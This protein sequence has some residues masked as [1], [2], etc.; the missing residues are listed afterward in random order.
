MSI[1]EGYNEATTA[2][3]ISVGF[4]ALVYIILFSFLGG[5]IRILKR[6][7]SVSENT[8]GRS[9]ISGFVR[10]ILFVGGI[11]S[12]IGAVG[13]IVAT[14]NTGADL[15]IFAISA[16]ATAVYQ[17]ALSRFIGRSK[18]ALRTV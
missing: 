5:C 7:I 18:K 16:A 9:R 11:F 13:W 8:A 2:L 15:V 14:F 10:F 12:A 4:T 6:Y 17:F 1:R 3:Y